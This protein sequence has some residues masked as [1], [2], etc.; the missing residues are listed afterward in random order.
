MIILINYRSQSTC[1]SCY[2]A[3][4]LQRPGSPPPQSRFTMWK[5]YEQGALVSVSSQIFNAFVNWER[6]FQMCKDF[7][8]EHRN[9]RQAILSNCTLPGILPTCHNLEKKILTKFINIRLYF[10]AKSLSL[11]ST[12]DNSCLGSKSMAQHSLVIHIK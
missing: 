6:V 8:L 2:S 10:Y 3:C 5:E 7:S 1:E 4:L 11:A 9:I 12:S